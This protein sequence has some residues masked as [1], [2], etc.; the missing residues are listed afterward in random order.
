[1]FLSF[2][3]FKTDYNVSFYD[4]LISRMRILFLYYSAWFEKCFF[5][6]SNSDMSF[7]FI[8]YSCYALMLEAI[9]SA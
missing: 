7:S 1:M 6:T 8:L 2:F 3:S 9:Y 5:K 4:R